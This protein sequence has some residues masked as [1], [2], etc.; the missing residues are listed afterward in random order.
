MANLA[1]KALG[2][3]GEDRAVAHM[4]AIGFELLE[5]NWRSPDREVPGEID[6][7]VQRD[8]DRR[9]LIVF[10]EVK[11]RRSGDHGGAVT[12]VG[13]VKQTKLRTLAE[14]WLRHH[15]VGEVDVRFDV[16][17]IDGVRL[18]HHEAAF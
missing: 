2:R 6:V 11:T 1:S 3:W 10:C 9:R 12:A 18:T 4:R 7:I 15:D 14:A 5:R 16:V 8:D 13:D 17:A